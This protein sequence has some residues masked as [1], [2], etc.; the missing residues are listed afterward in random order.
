MNDPTDRIEPSVKLQYLEALRLAAYNSFNDRR[1]Y[2]WKLSLA[3][4]TALAV[5]VAGLVHPI[6]TD[7]VFPFHGKRYGFLAAGIGF[8]VIA[9]HTYFNNGMARANAIDRTKQRIYEDQ[10]RASISFIKTE[11]Y[12]DE[13]AILKKQVEMRPKSP[14]LPY[15]QWRQWGHLAQIGVTF[16]L[17]ITAVII[18]WIRVTR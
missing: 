13:K 5:L 3:I 9:L 15:M 14:E 18:V 2:E 10:I 6:R 1:S 4:W 8:L 7:E 16:L 17:T 11:K 12:A